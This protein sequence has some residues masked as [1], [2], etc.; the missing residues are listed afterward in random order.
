MEKINKTKTFYLFAEPSFLEGFSRIIDLGDALSIYAY[1]DTAVHSDCLALK[2][3]WM[4]VGVDITK[5]ITIYESKY[6]ALT[7]AR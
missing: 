3:D 5:A 7:I 1:S 6:P 2:N 4:Q